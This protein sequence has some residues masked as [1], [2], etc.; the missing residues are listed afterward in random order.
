MIDPKR[1]QP[2]N[3][4]QPARG[5]YVL[6]WMQQSQRAEC[7]HALEYAI[8]RANDLGQGLLVAFGLTDDYPEANLRHY[9]FLLEGLR[10][11][12]EAL[13]KRGIPMLIRRGRPDDVALEMAADASLVVCDRGYLRH[14]KAWRRRVARSAQCQVVQVESD[15]VVPVDVASTKME[16][17]ARTI[18]PKVHKHW[19]RFLKPL[20]PTRLE[21]D[22]TLPRG[23]ALDLDDIDGVLAAMKIDR[24][25]PPVGG[26]FRGGGREARR[27][28]RSFLA[29]RLDRYDENSNQPQ[30]DDVSTMSPYL[31][32][33]HISP[34]EI[35]LA[36]RRHR[37]AASDRYLE[38]LLVRR[39]LA[40][41]FANFCD[42]YDRYECLPDWARRTLAKHA[43]DRRDPSYTARQLEDAG[44]HDPYWNAAMNEMKHTGFMHNY[45]RMYWGKKIL[46]WMDSPE[47]AHETALA[48]NNKYFLDGRDAN[49]F[50]NVGWVFGLHDR[51]WQE[52]PIFGTVRYMAASG[53]ERKCDPVAYVEKVERLKG[54]CPPIRNLRPCAK[55]GDH[56]TTK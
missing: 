44:T 45:M 11:T 26:F 47:L 49:S 17:A 34:L 46:E 2:L 6:Y 40:H 33:G 21:K 4:K 52:R 42:D 31:H 15:L 9:R 20:R 55:H 29:D 19:E 22:S 50:A 1:I 28:L 3:S 25:V 53:L 18:R 27:I 48:L 10:D 16:W 7:N 30:T 38:E 13:G 12:A 36:V 51:P 56:E 8:E 37:A 39:E 32:F 41:N 14:Q 23:D 5:A 24:S 43:R 35:A 54:L